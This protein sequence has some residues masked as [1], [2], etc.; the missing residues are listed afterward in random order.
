MT[1]SELADKI[2][3]LALEK[4]GKQIVK[5]DIKNLTDYA[6]YFVII[7]GDSGLQI[8]AIVDHIEDELAREGI[9]AYS[10]EGYEY[11]R[12]VLLDY[13][14]VVVHVFNHETREFYGIERL[15]ADAK[16][17]FITDEKV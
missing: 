11:Q 8:R 3:E 12:W 7:T 16:M 10:K 5:I 17:E 2:T 14:D 4:K 15:Y 6:D 13:V 9:K 1:S